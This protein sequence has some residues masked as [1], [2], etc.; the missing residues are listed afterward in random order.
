[1]RIL[2]E[3]HSDCTETDRHIP[4]PSPHHEPPDNRR[5]VARY[6][7]YGMLKIK[8]VLKGTSLLE[9]LTVLFQWLLAEQI[10]FGHPFVPIDVAP[11]PYLRARQLDVIKS[12]KA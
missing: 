8:A 5:V 3:A 1:M 6:F 11:F 2:L 12:T 4:H 10:S 9:P 7:R